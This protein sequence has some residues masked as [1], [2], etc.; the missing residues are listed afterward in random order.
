MPM[1][2]AA[3]G[4]GGIVLPFINAFANIYDPRRNWVS[5]IEVAWSLV[6]QSVLCSSRAASSSSIKA[7]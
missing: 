2:L 6:L 4:E 5:W 3:I 1:L 7:A